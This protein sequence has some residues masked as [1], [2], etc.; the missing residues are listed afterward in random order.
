L[1]GIHGF[2][3]NFFGCKECSHHFTQM[4]ADDG[5]LMITPMKD[6]VLWLWKAHNKVNKRLKGTLSEDPGFPKTQFPTD[7][8]CSDCYLKENVFD[9]SEVLQY[10]LKMYSKPERT[11]VHVKPS[12][13]RIYS[14]GARMSNS[15]FFSGID[16][17]LFG[18]VYIL[19][20]AILVFAYIHFRVRSIRFT[21]P[22]SSFWFR[23]VKHH[24][25]G[26]SNV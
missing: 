25:V 18:G 10:L 22:S 26:K 2:V 6:Q 11:L 4:V 13:E 5:A 15:R 24:Y 3:K 1:D 20:A 16:Y 8:Q 7:T 17:W 9:E 23:R 21:I 14:T 12:T 19:V